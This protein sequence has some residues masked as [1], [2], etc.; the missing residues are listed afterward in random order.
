MANLH[1]DGNHTT[2]EE[3]FCKEGITDIHQNIF[4]PALNILLSITAFLGNVLIIVAIPKVSSLHPPSK[5][6]FRS[7]AST[8]LC[9]GLITQP[10]YL[11]SSLMPSSPAHS[12]RCHYKYSGFLARATGTIFCELS[13]LT[14]TAISV[15]RLLALLLGLR[16]RQVVTMRRVQVFVV[17]SWP[18]SIAIA[19]T[20]F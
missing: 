9:V 4:I 20:S 7:L 19:S 18:S 17:I 15:D 5:L 13:L 3:L 6:L 2:T 14:L 11:F 1:E 10:L 12:L 8:D 16:Y